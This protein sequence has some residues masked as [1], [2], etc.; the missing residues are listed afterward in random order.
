[1]GISIT[2]ENKIQYNVDMA[3]RVWLFP[4]LCNTFEEI[5]MKHY[6]VSW[7]YHLFLCQ[8]YFQTVPSWFDYFSNIC[9]FNEIQKHHCNAQFIKISISE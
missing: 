2:V 9:S 5:N 7:F 4:Q 3:D 8:T 1:M 6:D